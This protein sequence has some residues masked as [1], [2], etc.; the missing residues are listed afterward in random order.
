MSGASADIPAEMERT[1]RAVERFEANFDA[2]AKIIA[3]VEESLVSLV[4]TLNNNDQG[5]HDAETELLLKGGV[6]LDTL[7]TFLVNLCVCVCVCVCVC[8]RA[9]VFDSSSP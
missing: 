1:R 7:E 3:G 2:D 6:N 4:N 8:A 5:H 9:R